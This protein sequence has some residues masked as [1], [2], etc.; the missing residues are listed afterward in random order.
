MIER[1]DLGSWMDGTPRDPD[2]QRGSRLGLPPTGSGSVA[3]Y[4]RRFGSVL[5]DW[6]LC[7][8]VAFVAFA[9]DPLMVL[10]LFIGLN[11]VMLTLVGTTISQ[12]VLGLRVT[13]V[14]GRRPMVVRALVRTAMILLLLPVI[15]VDRDGRGLQDVL[16]GTATIR[17]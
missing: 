2:Y 1:N 5:G 6:L 16:S 15:F 13:P 17:R 10:W 7:R 12:Y 4:G 9:D 11:L 14:V 8:G 3:G